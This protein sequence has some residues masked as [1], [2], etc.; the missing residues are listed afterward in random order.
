MCTASDGSAESIR[1]LRV[2]IAERRARLL[3]LEAELARLLAD[4][5][6]RPG[7]GS[8]QPALFVTDAQVRLF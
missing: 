7:D 5:G 1:A 4:A 6:R 2:E 8:D 3:A